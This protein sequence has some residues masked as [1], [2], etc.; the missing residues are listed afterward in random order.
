MGKTPEVKCI[1]ITPDGVK[2]K[3]LGDKVQDAEA[4][5]EAAEKPVS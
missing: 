3:D 4:V 2:V 5:L 1:D